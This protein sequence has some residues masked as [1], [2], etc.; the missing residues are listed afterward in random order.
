M[1]DFVLDMFTLFGPVPPRRGE[2]GTAQ[3]Q[4]LL[5][6][7]QIAGAVTLSTRGLYHSAAAGNRETIALC[8]EAGPKLA[9]A[10]V[11]DPRFPNAERTVAGGRVLCLL[12]DT[13]HWPLPFAPVT[14]LLRTLIASGGTIAA[15]IPLWWEAHKPGDAT[16]IAHVLEQVNYPAPVIL[17]NVA[18]NCLYE[19]L[20]VARQNEKL[21]IATNGLQ[22]L[23][24]VKMAVDAI[25]AK[26]VVFGSGAPARSLGAALSLVRNAGLSEPDKE[27]V[28][29]GNARS[30]LASS[31]AN[32]GAQ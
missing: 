28:L 27:A 5:D 20:T 13:Q 1:P 7:H 21:L 30:L 29:G 9:P 10:V 19:A 17:G 12:P 23:G 6:A 2:T 31:V 4:A 18:G 8:Q 22:G 32:G 25:G 16:Q 24:E 11:L 3:L 26:R 14:E 15:N